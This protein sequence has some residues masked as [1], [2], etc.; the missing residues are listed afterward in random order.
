MSVSILATP[1]VAAPVGMAALAVTTVVLAAIG[2]MWRATAPS[3]IVA[4]PA[5]MGLG[6]ERPAIVDMLVGGFTVDEDA[7]PATVVDLAHRGHFTIEKYGDRTVLRLREHVTDRRRLTAYEQ[8]VLSHIRAKAVDGVTPAEV[9]TLGDL[10]VSR[11]WFAAFAREVAADARRLGL[12]RRRWR[13]RQLLVVW[14]LVVVAFA[15]PVLAAMLAPYTADSFGW[16]S[17]G[18]VLLGVAF[19]GAFVAA[20]LARTATLGGAHVDTEAGREAA[21][22][23]LGVRDYY[24]ASGDFRTKEAAAVAVWDDHLAYAT[25]MGLARR[26]E[27]EL[28]FA[29]ESDTR[30]WSNVTGDWRKVKV[31]YRSPR[32][33]WGQHP[34]RVVLSAL[35]QG[36]LVAFVGFLAFQVAVGDSP[37][38]EQ[39]FVTGEREGAVSLAATI[40]AIVCGVLVAYCAVKLAI[41]AADLFRRRTIEGV[42][43]RRRSYAQGFDKHTERIEQRYRLPFRIRFRF[44]T[45]DPTDTGRRSQRNRF[46]AIDDGT[47]DRIRAFKVTG[48]R[49]AQFA[50]GDTVRVR[51][52]PLLGHVADVTT[53]A[54]AARSGGHDVVARSAEIF[55]DEIAGYVARLAQ[56]ADSRLPRSPGEPPDAP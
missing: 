22:R 48:R 26:V 3:R 32:L 1:D 17:A 49:Y 25:A 41:G 43:L 42:V 24:R 40:L 9:L 35:V 16:G 31:S 44:G 14:G 28:P 52:S 39:E 30:A 56:V 50:Q 36:A 10:G 38:T 45:S 23:W 15:G 4:E 55:G 2:W 53:I 27:R 46:V 33:C 37:L 11:R 7:V 51:F 5:A 20:W 13:L 19:V 6:D 47:S 54:A 21:A 12:C 18:N 8:R 29:A 34:F